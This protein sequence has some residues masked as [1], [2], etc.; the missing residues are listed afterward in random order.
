MICVHVF[1]R[2]LGFG[3]FF[4][5]FFGLFLSF[6]AAPAAYGCSQARG[7]IRAVAA[8]LCQSYSNA[9]SEPCLRPTPQLT[10]T[11]DP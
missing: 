2:F 9:G 6:R 5:F 1:H 10:A 4:F 7:R 3:F 8:G 11:P